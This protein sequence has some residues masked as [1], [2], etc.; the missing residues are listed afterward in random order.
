MKRA[1]NFVL[2]G[3]ELVGV[4][5]CG[6]SFT[7]WNVASL[8]S[9]DPA[10][11]VFFLAG[12]YLVTLAG[13]LCL[14]AL[15]PFR[16]QPD[17]PTSFLCGFFAF[18][19]ALFILSLAL[20]LGIVG[21]GLIVILVAIAWGL[22][23]GSRPP[24][25]TSTT[26]RSLPGLAVAL[27]SLLAATLWSA[28][29]IR[30][31]DESHGIVVFKPWSDCFVH[32]CMVRMFR[33]AHG[34]GTLEN[35]MLPGRPPQVYH[36]A[37][38]AVPALLAA[39]TGT[40]CYEALTSFLIPAGVVLTGFAA[41]SLAG[42]WWGPYAG[43]AAAV[44]VLLLPDP[45]F[46]GIGNP[47][48]S[49]HWLQQ[50]A[51]TGTYGVAL[52]SLAWLFF[53]EGCRTGNRLATCVGLIVAGLVLFY[54]AHIFV[55]IAFPIWVAPALMVPT[56]RPRWRVVWLVSAVALFLAI[57]SLSRVVPAVPR[58]RLDGSGMSHYVSKLALN[59]PNG[60]WRERLA[61]G[62]SAVG[63]A[64]ASTGVAHLFLGT[65]GALGLA[66]VALVVLLLRRE[67]GA[68]TNVAER[69]PEE[70]RYRVAV[71][72]FVPVVILT[73]LVMALGLAPDRNP[74]TQVDELQHRPLVWA[75][76][77][78]AA[79]VGGAC[80]ELGL[81]R[82]FA[83]SHFARITTSTAVCGLLAVP[84]FLGRDVEVGPG[85][86]KEVTN[87]PMSMSFCKCAR[88]LRE[89]SGRGEVV[90]DSL[91]SPDKALGA[92]SERPE[93]VIEYPDGPKQALL[94]DRLDAI[95]RLE[96]I[97]DAAELKRSAAK[98]G[99][100]WY[101]LRPNNRVAWD[102]RFVARPSFESGGYRVYSLSDRSR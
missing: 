1:T 56:V 38:Y 36:Y 78:T 86:G 91:L 70:T 79:W 80:Y 42:S 21:D 43:L 26:G 19:T 31:L 97:V 12:S 3:P 69:P 44:A 84:F 57:A 11:L 33:D 34:V 7:G 41:Y 15:L 48:L 54:K 63:L 22:A 92:L 45:S 20:P 59:L 93:Y 53:F 24:S 52:A 89:H 87:T 100:S 55:A 76:F 102:P 58:L 66:A 83:R 98:L 90:Q 68:V 65:F 62:P 32:S 13:K 27:V 29:A 64:V 60:P 8:G 35:I 17:F 81:K 101:V 14:R 71:A 9:F 95:R 72:L 10:T 77:V 49:Y 94:A 67:G 73:Y 61:V 4:A 99:I 88:Y 16:S 74:V 30:P 25:L 5:L 28:D 75:Y 50:V 47:F 6:L 96:R 23:T 2:A 51:P 46:Y 37:T 40:P 18:S 85:W 39:V 82:W